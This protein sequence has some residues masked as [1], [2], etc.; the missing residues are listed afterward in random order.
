MS[1]VG[2][3]SMTALQRGLD[4]QIAQL[5]SIE[6]LLPLILTDAAR[7]SDLN[8][9]ESEIQL[10][11]SAILDAKQG[12]AQIDIDPPCGFGA[13]EDEIK[14]NIEKLTH[15]LSESVIRITEKVT[16][17]ISDAV[18]EALSAAAG[19]IGDHLSE[20]VA[21]HM[22]RLRTEHAKRAE[23]VRKLW[24]LAFDQLDLLRHI[25]LEWSHEARLLRSGP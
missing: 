8:V 9:S 23:T 18:P 15:D 6:Q 4:R 5:T 21:E 11:T 2:M 25:V 10:L 7:R 3:K 14:V 17:A 16:A 12:I 19:V 24:G 1:S 13:T 20:N 22:S